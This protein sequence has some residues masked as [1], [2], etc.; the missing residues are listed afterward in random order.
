LASRGL[1]ALLLVAAAAGADVRLP[2][3]FG[4]GMVLQRDTKL[5]IWG[6]AEPGERVEVALAGETAAAVA[7]ADRRWSVR[8][9][10][11]GAS[12]GLTL[13][14][15]GR[16]R[17]VVE[18][19]LVGDVWLC[20]GQSNLGWPVEAADGGGEAEPDVRLRLFTVPARVSN[21]PQTDV[22]ARWEHA[23]ASSVPRFSAV[24]YGFGRRV[25]ERLGVPVGLI[26]ACVAG[27][28]AEAWTSREALAADPALAPLVTRDAGA[29]EDRPGPH[30]PGGLF[31]GM[32]APLV[33]YALCGVLWYQGESNASRAEQYA[34][35]FPALI[36]DWRRAWGRGDFPFLYV[37]LANFG[38]RTA[39]PGESA[40]AELREAQRLALALPHTAMAVAIDLGEADDI[41]PRQKREVA[42]RLHLAAL[43]VAYGGEGMV[44]SGPRFL[45]CEA[46]EGGLVL[47]FRDAE[48]G[49]TTSDGRPPRG[50]AVAGEDRVWRR[51]EVRLEG[52]TAVVGHPDLSHPVAVRYAWA[53]NPDANLCNAAGLPAS[54][55]RTDAWPLLTAGRR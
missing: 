36:R 15:A 13:V 9:G 55:F 17:V 34:T 42:R 44:C 43:D 40:W 11:F 19:V 49:L 16:N 26:Q 31:H 3:L 39:E 18:G 41:H 6:W 48:G 14:A 50:F 53:D 21:D 32:I 35:L 46:R 25:R 54:P 7:G 20:A 24:A 5:E 38:A 30:R 12:A 45:D 29:D 2:A 22:A 23:D 37:Q 27:T 33:P 51:A 47:R 8:M 52:S 1:P 28:P 10:P 4:D